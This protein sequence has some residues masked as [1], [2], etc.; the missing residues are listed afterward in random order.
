MF[1][2]H[3]H[4]RKH[5]ICPNCETILKPEDN[6]CPTCGQ[7]NHDLKIPLGHLIYEFVES[8]THFDNK[9][10]ETLK[11]ILK[12]GK[13]TRDFLDGKRVRYVPPARLYIFVSFVFF[14]LLNT[15]Y[16]R[17]L[18]NKRL[19]DVISYNFELG[20]RKITFTRQEIN[21]VKNYSESQLDSLLRDKQIPATPVNRRELKEG[22]IEFGKDSL[23]FGLIVDKKALT[24]AEIESYRRMTDEQLS[25]VL[26]RLHLPQTA[27]TR[28]LLRQSPK[29]LVDS[30][31]KGF[32]HKLFKTLSIVMFVLMPVVAFLLLALY[33][34]RRLYYYEHLIFSVHFH[35]ITFLAFSMAILF[36]WLLNIEFFRS[37]TVLVLLFYL[38]KSLRFI[39]G[40]SRFKTISIYL[41][42]IISYC[43]LAI[44]CVF[45]AVFYSALYF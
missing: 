13:L 23:S 37:V 26:K 10:W 30:D 32:T 38:Y 40:Q 12:P 25:A 2:T 11:A 1:V 3:K 14:L 9:L 39:Y 20:N 44:I 22:I 19:E 8:I 28:Q 31:L 5:T 42:L 17:S 36:D 45:G 16:D 24:K 43:I 18:T 35:T 6:F 15:V 29:L 27:L 21:L 7:E 4:R 33:Y 41:L 34:R